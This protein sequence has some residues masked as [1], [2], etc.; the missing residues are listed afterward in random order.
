MQNYYAS[1]AQGI[2]YLWYF[3]QQ[4]CGICRKG[5]FLQP[6]ALLIGGAGIDELHVGF[7]GFDVMAYAGLFLESVGSPFND[8]LYLAGYNCLG[9]LA[10]KCIE[11][12]GT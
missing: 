10:T 6:Y 12:C 7:C 2:P 1:F 8:C 4:R 3:G 11:K 9:I 5:Q